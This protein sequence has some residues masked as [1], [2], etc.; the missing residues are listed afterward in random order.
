MA[1]AIDNLILSMQQG[2]AVTSVIISHD[3]ESTL[4][5]ADQVAMLHEGRI[6][7]CAPPEAFARS[8]N[9]VVQN[10]LQ[11]GR[12]ANSRRGMS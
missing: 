1:V 12:H 10:F 11:A 6:I 7:E 4:R 9:P 2:L 5:V 3:I 8:D